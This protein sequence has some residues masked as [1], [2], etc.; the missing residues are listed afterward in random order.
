MTLPLT[1]NRERL[2]GRKEIF[3]E[4]IRIFDSR[5]QL[6]KD[7]RDAE[8][9]LQ[10]AGTNDFAYCFRID[11]AIEEASFLRNVIVLK[12][13]Q[14]NLDLRKLDKKEHYD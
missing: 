2:I 9:K 14:P 8:S 3:D 6:L 4:C 12:S 11:D 13:Y 7:A 10:Q 1:E 5:I